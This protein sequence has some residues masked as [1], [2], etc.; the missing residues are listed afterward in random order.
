MWSLGEIKHQAKRGLIVC[1]S[2][3]AMA[4]AL[5]IYSL[6][7]RNGLSGKWWCTCG[8]F[9]TVAGLVQLEVSGCFAKFW[10]SYSD[11]EY[12]YG[13]PSYICREII[14]N[15]D[16]PISEYLRTSLFQVPAT[17]F[18]FLVIGTLVQVLGTW[19]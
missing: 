6:L 16:A 9:L 13:P 19:T 8:L 1:L 3:A 2:L 14:V 11:E 10:D 18:W 5:A 12:P 17:G 4:A 7:A 15:P